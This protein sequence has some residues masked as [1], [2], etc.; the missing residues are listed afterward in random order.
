[1]TLDLFL[2]SLMLSKENFT[3]KDSTTV[4]VNREYH[5]SVF[6]YQI[7]QVRPDTAKEWRGLLSQSYVFLV[8]SDKLD[9]CPD[10]T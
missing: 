7:Y 3:V 2:F 10:I 8:E 1:M 4:Y 9:R 5:V 6:K